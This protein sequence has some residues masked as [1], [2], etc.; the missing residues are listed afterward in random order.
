LRT[1]ASEIELDARLADAALI[2]PQVSG[3]VRLTANAAEV[4]G[5]WE[6]A[7]D[8]GFQR[9]TLTATGTAVDVFKTPVIAA[10]GR[11]VAD[12]L[13]DFADLAQRPLSGSIDTRFSTE[14]AADLSR[15]TLNLD[16]AATDLRI[17]QDQADALLTGEVAI[18]ADVAVANQVVTV[19]QSSIN[20]PAANVFADGTL[21]ATAGTFDVS[22]RITDLATIL[23]GAPSGPL[24]FEAQTTRDGDNWGFE[25]KTNSQA[26]ALAS[27]GTISDPTGPTPEIQAAFDGALSDLS[28]FSEIANRR[29]SGSLKFEASGRATADLARFD[30]DATLSGA[31]VTTGISELDAALAGALSAEIKAARDGAAIRIDTARIASDLVSVTAEGELGP[32]GSA[33]ALDASLA[34]V[35]PFVPGFSGAATINGTITQAEDARLAVDLDA[36]GPG[37]ARAAIAGDTAIDA[38]QMSLGITGSAPLGLLNRFLA[39]RSLAGD[40]GFDLRLEGAPALENLSGRLSSADARLVAPAL[41]ITLD[42]TNLNV[43]LANANASVSA[44]AN[45]ST[46]GRL[47]VEGQLALNGERNA[48]LDIRLIDVVLSDPQ[49]YETEISGTVSINGAL[50]GGARIAGNLELGETNIRIPS[51]GFGGAGAIPE[52]IHI[53]EPPPV[54]GT[55]GRAGLLQS[56]DDTRAESGPA[57]PLDIA[58]SSPNRIFIRGRGL[59]SEFGGALRITGTTADVVP[60]G[61]F[62]LIRGRL[63]ILGQRLALEEATVTIQGSFIPVLRIRATTDADDVSVAVIVAGPANNP[64]ITFTSDPEL[65][66]EEVLARLLFGRELQNLSPIQA[67]RLALAVR[68]LAGQGGEG[69]ISNVR[70]GVGLADFDV[71]SDE[72]GNAA[73]R[74]GAYI[75]ENIYT[76]VTVTATGDTELNLNLDLNESI[77]LKGS[78]ATDGDSSIGVFFERDY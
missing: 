37:G 21:S 67:G 26:I 48:D 17:G 58:I 14:V 46:G 9:T 33:I 65:P 51:S 50:S 44:V 2:L 3:P 20:G 63:D 34:N 1:A 53:N 27:N 76:D 28:V 22:G 38:S 57:F 70:Q 24:E 41:G 7:L 72:D 40:I 60:Q 18:I 25:V 74:A 39:P 15:I 5:R 69:I 54:R 4:D 78:A 52:I 42:N 6:W 43:T 31:N 10:N 32:V 56:T 19:R 61:A 45:V 13:A 36:T 59:D 29:L 77:T 16:G 23:T 73:V 47:G 55:R 68:T 12:D 11:L 64:E 62:N 71:T 30:I 49:L 66:Q 35:A 8:S 75:G